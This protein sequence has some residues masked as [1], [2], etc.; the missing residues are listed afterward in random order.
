MSDHIDW[1]PA[2]RDDLPAL[3][4]LI[5]TIQLAEGEKEMVTAE[6]V[7]QSFDDSQW[8]PATD[9]LLAWTP[10]GDLV[11]Q[12]VVAT[13]GR[14]RGMLR[15]MMWGGVRP[16]WRGR[17]LGRH[18]AEW[19]IRRAEQR[20]HE[21][22]VTIPGLL[23]FATEVG[24]DD[25]RLF[26]RLGFSPRRYWFHMDHDLVTIARPAST[27][28][29]VET[30]RPELFEPIR[31]AHNEAFADHWGSE[32][33]SAEV[34]REMVTGYPSFCP[35]LSFAALDGETVAAYL[36]SFDS[37][38]AD[39]HATPSIHFGKIGTRKAY[40]RRGLA[41]SLIATALRG[42]RDRGYGHASL[43]VDAGNATGAVGVYEKAGFVVGERTVSYGRDLAPM[44]TIAKP[45]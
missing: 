13:S 24:H 20:Y 31:Q 39:P 14:G 7:E 16:D 34:Y 45:G 29:R 41:S 15:V 44:I 3:T 22:G 33:R 1:R 26:R 32:E 19:Q 6:D 23:E 43:G 25:E 37:E 4:A 38:L 35:E 5:R 36:M 10:D 40:R 9:S 18:L 12:G 21:S 17:G 11:A 27:G 8:Y 28:L 30:Y 2:T 42:A